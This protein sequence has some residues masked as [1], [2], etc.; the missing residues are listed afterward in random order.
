MVIKFISVSLTTPANAARKLLIRRPIQGDGR[1]NGFPKTT[2]VIKECL[3]R[4]VT[5]LTCQPQDERVVMLSEDT[6]EEG[7]NCSCKQLLNMPTLHQ[8]RKVC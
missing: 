8:H 7:L 6:K 2:T 3:K 4:A 1:F 5:P